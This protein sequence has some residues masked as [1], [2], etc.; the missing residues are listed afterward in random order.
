[1]ERAGGN[2]M[3]E[4]WPAGCAVLA[5][6]LL[7]VLIIRYRVHAFAALLG[8]TLA[9]GLATGM[10]PACVVD[11]VGK[12]VGDILREVA[13]ILALGAMLGRMLEVSGAAEVIAQTL[14]NFCGA[15]RAPVAIFAAGYL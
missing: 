15:G 11:A 9:L 1:M 14:I 12:G 5:L 7:L 13:L 2:T 8:V 4:Y 6:A 10:E 3:S